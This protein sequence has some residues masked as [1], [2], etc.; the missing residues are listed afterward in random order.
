MKIKQ[1]LDD[2]TTGDL[3]FFRTSKKRCFC[4][5]SSLS[6]I[7]D[8]NIFLVVNKTTME[9]LSGATL[10]KIEWLNLTTATRG[11]LLLSE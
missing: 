6:K 9:G 2:L 11:S 1:N 3:F 4:P 10:S 5:G 7:G 8:N